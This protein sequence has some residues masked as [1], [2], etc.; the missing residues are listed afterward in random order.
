MIN[1]LLVLHI[2][3]AVL[4][5]A[6]VLLQKSEGGALGMGGSGGNMGGLMSTRGAANLLT[7][8]TGVL[9]TLFFLTTLG[10]ALLFKGGASQKSLLDAVETS[11][12]A[13]H[14]ATDTAH[15][16]DAA[17]P[18]SET[19]SPDVSG[20]SKT[21]NFPTVPVGQGTSSSPNPS[22]TGK[23][24]LPGSPGS[25]GSQTKSSKASP[26]PVSRKGKGNG[27]GKK[28]AK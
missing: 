22:R 16:K 5:I 6:L 8:T 7:R 12:K 19:S 20:A 1:A 23:G 3:L 9:A 18:S 25:S 17:L 10:L 14:E 21:G 2:I 28:S 15:P 27:K 26:S 11:P 13:S 4:M 24:S